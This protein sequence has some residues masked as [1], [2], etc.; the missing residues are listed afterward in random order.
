[1]YNKIKGRDERGGK[2]EGIIGEIKGKKDKVCDCERSISVLLSVW[3][4]VVMAAV[5]CELF[6][7]ALASG[8]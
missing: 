1:M 2:K 7:L 6:G 5:L 8:L 4:E 3:L